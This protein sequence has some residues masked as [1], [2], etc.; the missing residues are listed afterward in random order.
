M[1]RQADRV[2]QSIVRMGFVPEMGLFQHPGLI[3]LAGEIGLKVS[4]NP[5]SLCRSGLKLNHAVR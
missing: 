5:E 4:K 2:A 3:E 1:G